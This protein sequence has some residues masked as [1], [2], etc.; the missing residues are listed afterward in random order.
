MEVED[1]LIN[2]S[3]TLDELKDDFYCDDSEKA[4]KQLIAPEKST[5]ERVST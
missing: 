2:I 4:A 3:V 1:T 5:A